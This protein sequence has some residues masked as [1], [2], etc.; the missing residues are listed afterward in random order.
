MSTLEMLKLKHQLERQ[1]IDLQ[2]VNDVL[3]AKASTKF[4]VR[5]DCDELKRKSTNEDQVQRPAKQTKFHRNQTNGKRK[6][7]TSIFL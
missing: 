5:V 4:T 1:L 2:I 7:E 3:K 6:H